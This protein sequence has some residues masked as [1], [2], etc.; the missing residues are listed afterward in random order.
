MNTKS[1]GKFTKFPKKFETSYVF[2]DTINR[3]F[4]NLSEKQNIEMMTKKTQLP[5]LFTY[6]PYPMELQYSLIDTT[7]LEHYNT[8]TWQ[9]SSK[10]VPILVKYSFLLTWNTLD[11]TTL[12]SFE[13]VVVNPELIPLDQHTK[14]ISGCKNVCLEMI[15]G[16]EELLQLNKENIYEYESDII[17]AP[18]DA[19]WEYVV[20]FENIVRDLFGIT[21]YE[22]VSEKVGEIVSFYL[23]GDEDKKSIKIVKISNNPNKKKWKFCI[24]PLGGPFREQIIK[25]ILVKISDNDTFLSIFH[26][27]QD[28]L[29]TEDLKNLECKK[30]S[31]LTFLRNKLERK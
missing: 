3:V 9:I 19:V 10:I 1:S 6:K 7:S 23:P 24:S 8:I 30:K 22:G 18:L 27:F 21:K 4:T 26:E 15:N 14:V 31:L 11:S 16:L 13:I 12:V 2:P 29:E 28:L 25:F 20:H 5:Y 17:H